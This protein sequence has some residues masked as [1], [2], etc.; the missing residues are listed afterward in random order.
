[1]TNIENIH[2]LRDEIKRLREQSKQQE[3]LIKDD[4]R[5]VREDLKP[6]NILWSALSSITGIKTDRSEF[7]K[8]GI[9][10]S[11]S[12]LI[13]RFILKTERKAEH[14]FYGVVDDLF[15]RIKKFI[16]KFGG[17]EA[18]KA[19]RNEAREDFTAGE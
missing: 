17:S 10:Y 8:N 4:L 13:R 6:Q 3:L 18:R 12:I 2:Q 5:E 19:E 14:A 15:E 16:N 1:M 11:V 7:F 9:A